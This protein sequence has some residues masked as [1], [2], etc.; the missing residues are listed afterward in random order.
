MDGPDLSVLG[1]MALLVG[2]YRPVELVV[3]VVAPVWP[4]CILLLMQPMGWLK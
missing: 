4:F 2:G 1:P 3:W